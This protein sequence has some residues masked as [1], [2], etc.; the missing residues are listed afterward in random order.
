MCVRV[1][2]RSPG[3]GRH[4]SAVFVNEVSAS[5]QHPAVVEG[6]EGVSSRGGR[7]LAIL[8]VGVLQGRELVFAQD[9]VHDKHPFLGMQAKS[10]TDCQTQ[11]RLGWK[12]E[13]RVK[14]TEFVCKDCRFGLNEGWVLLALASRSFAAQRCS[15]LLFPFKHL[16]SG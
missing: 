7:V 13:F 10:G 4:P 15:A 6:G 12:S 8:S 16:E 1:C 14:Q 5:V 9:L 11:Q 2:E 3:D